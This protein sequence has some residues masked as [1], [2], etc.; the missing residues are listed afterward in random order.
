[1]INHPLSF[2]TLSA[3][4]VKRNY[5]IFSKYVNKNLS[6][7]HSRDQNLVFIGFFAYFGESRLNY[8]SPA[9]KVYP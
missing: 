7:S 6:I 4:K 3:S 2:I 9:L 1:M 5:I 8:L